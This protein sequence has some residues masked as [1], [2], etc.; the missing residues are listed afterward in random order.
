MKKL[1]VLLIVLLLVSPA[2]AATKHKKKKAKRVVTP[3]S[4]P[5]ATPVET[6]ETTPVATPM[7]KPV[8]ESSNASTDHWVLQFQGGPD[9]ILSTMT[10]AATINS[11]GW[12][13]N[14]SFGYAPDNTWSFSFLTGY[15]VSAI[16]PPG[17][18]PGS[19]GYSIAYTPLQLVTQCNFLG[20]DVRLYMLLGAGLALNSMTHDDPKDGISEWQGI[21]ENGFLLS[22]GLGVAIKLSDKTNIF[23]QSKLDMAFFSQA[24]ADQITDMGP[25]TKPFETLQLFVPIQMGFSF[26]LN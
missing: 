24:F 23:I 17:D 13:F 12:G 26:Y 5:V 15:Q 25:T 21:K 8:A 22:P 6:P 2:L 16:T 7:A 10:D 1:L 19:E 18:D 3:V 11:P 14:G 4:T 20:D 9:F